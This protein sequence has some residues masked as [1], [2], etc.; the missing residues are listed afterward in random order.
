M[1]ACAFTACLLTV[2]PD[3]RPSRTSIT[4]GVYNESCIWLAG[5]TISVECHGLN[6]GRTGSARRSVDADTSC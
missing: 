2:L 5:V 6:S 3:S 1:Q 4:V